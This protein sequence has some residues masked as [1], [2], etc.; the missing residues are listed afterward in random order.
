MFKVFDALIIL[1][2]IAAFRLI[3]VPI[4]DIGAVFSKLSVPYKTANSFT[5][6]YTFSEIGLA[7]YGKSSS[8]GNKVIKLVHL[9]LDLL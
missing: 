5:V 9:C 4:N 7:K 2:S 3:L 6:L 8:I 1:F